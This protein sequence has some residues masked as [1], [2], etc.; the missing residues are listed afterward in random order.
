MT[1]FELIVILIFATGYII[2]LKK[3]QPPLG[4]RKAVNSLTN[5]LGRGS[6]LRWFSSYPYHSR[7]TTRLQ[8]C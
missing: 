6:R 1:S 7:F 4:Q 8:V 3:K 2:V 5:I